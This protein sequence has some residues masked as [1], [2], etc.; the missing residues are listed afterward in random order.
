MAAE[1]AKF[2]YT[3]RQRKGLARSELAKLLEVSSETI[4]RFETSGAAPSEE[5]CK[6]LQVALGLSSRDAEMLR[7]LICQSMIDKRMK[8]TPYRLRVSSV[9]DV[10][11][12]I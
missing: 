6:K 1:Y 12:E 2:L 9:D 5:A 7:I 3:R 10:P 11:P 8:D 4:R